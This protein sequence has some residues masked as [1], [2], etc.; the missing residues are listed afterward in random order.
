[1]R[2]HPRQ[3]KPY[4]AKFKGMAIMIQGSQWLQQYYVSGEKTGKDAGARTQ[5]AWWTWQGAWTY[6]GSHSRLYVTLWQQ[7]GG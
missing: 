3:G 7:G 6:S 4:I 5:R 1:M 2:D